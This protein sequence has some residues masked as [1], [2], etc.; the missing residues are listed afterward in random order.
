MITPLFR[1]QLLQKGDGSLHITM[2]LG[3]L[4]AQLPVPEKYMDPA[5]VGFTEFYKLAI[6]EMTK[7]LKKLHKEEMIKLKREK[8]FRNGYQNKRADRRGDST[9]N[10]S[11]DAAP[12]GPR[13]V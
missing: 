6:A 3:E 10:D 13:G 7:G 11:T 12:D 8:K 5:A 2:S 4:N 9:T 1:S